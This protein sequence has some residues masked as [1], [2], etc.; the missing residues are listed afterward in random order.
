[1]F[2]KTIVLAM[3]LALV[4][5][6]PTRQDST[7]HM[8]FALQTNSELNTAVAVFWLPGNL[9][10]FDQQTFITSLAADLIADGTKN[11]GR[12]A[13]S[14]PACARSSERRSHGYKPLR[15]KRMSCKMT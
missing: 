15:H 12:S 5:A 4:A 7:P 11:A 1:M 10:S 14:W 13:R 9:S 6:A 2:L 8:A 3:C